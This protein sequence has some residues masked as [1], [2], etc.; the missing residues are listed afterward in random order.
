MV[1]ILQ[2]L[3]VKHDIPVIINNE[4]IILEKL[5]EEYATLYA[6]YIKTDYVNKNTFNR[7]FTK[8]FFKVLPKD[9]IKKYSLKSVTE[10]DFP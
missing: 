3:Y 10:I 4:K 5:A 6:K 2:N 1:L 9:L 8:D 7:N